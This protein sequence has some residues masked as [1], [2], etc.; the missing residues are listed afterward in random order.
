M[1]VPETLAT[2][3]NPETTLA[4]IAQLPT[5]M[6]APSVL[7]VNALPQVSPPTT[8]AITVNVLF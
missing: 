5:G 7:S 1:V 4:V 6:G 2:D 3:S 8:V